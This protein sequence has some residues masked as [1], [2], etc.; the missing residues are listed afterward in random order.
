M[1]SKVS[2][3]LDLEMETEDEKL[4]SFSFGVQR[5]VSQHQEYKNVLV[6]HHSQCK[7]FKA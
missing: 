6:T 4:L 5:S 3:S 2:V 1:F 7:T